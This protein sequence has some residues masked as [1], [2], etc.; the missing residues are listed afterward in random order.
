MSWMIVLPLLSLAND[1]PDLGKKPLRKDDWQ[2]EGRQG[3]PEKGS[4]E[5]SANARDEKAKGL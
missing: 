3:S 1:G 4:S 2:R 5:D